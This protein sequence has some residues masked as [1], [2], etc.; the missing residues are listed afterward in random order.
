MKNSL[1]RLLLC[2]SLALPL[3]GS[4]CSSAAGA[5]QSAKQEKPV[6]KRYPPLVR[7][8]DEVDIM[9]GATDADLAVLKTMR[10]IKAVGADVGVNGH[11]A[12]ITDAGFVYLKSLTGLRTLRLLNG[13]ITDVGLAHLAGLTELTELWL[14]GNSKITDAGLAHL[15]GLRKLK[16]LRFH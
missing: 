15:K 16:T 3:F 5:P 9:M 11:C 4:T 12:S 8:G 14:D 7:R 6:I 13:K 1:I 2:L 10:G